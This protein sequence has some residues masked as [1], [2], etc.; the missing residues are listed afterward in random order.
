M[1]AD[2][3][4]T[5]NHQDRAEKMTATPVGSP[6]RLDYGLDTL[7]GSISKSAECLIGLEVEPDQAPLLCVP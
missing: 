1:A 7:S 5:G 2:E 6:A 3:L 4:I